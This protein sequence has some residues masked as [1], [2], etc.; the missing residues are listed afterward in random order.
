LG[1]IGGIFWIIHEIGLQLHWGKFQLIQVGCHDAISRPDGAA[2]E[3]QSGLMYLGSLVSE[4][5]RACS[6]LHRR[7]GVAQGEFRNLSRLWRHSSLGRH[8]T[9]LSKLLYGLPAVWLNAAEKRKLNGFQ[10]RC[11]RM[12]WGIKPAYYSRISNA[13][14]LAITRQTSLEKSLE[15]RQLLL[16]GRVARQ[17]DTNPMRAATFIPGTLESATNRYVKKV[18]RPRLTWAT[19]VGKLAL[20]VSGGL[21]RLNETLFDSGS[22]RNLLET[23]YA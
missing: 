15:K 21:K 1:E 18:G 13:K 8:R 7:L 11:L 12:A 6:E 5:G 16:Y 3:R 4:D 23:H 17:E 19:E 2:I 20:K 22:W 9:V 14:V 10:N